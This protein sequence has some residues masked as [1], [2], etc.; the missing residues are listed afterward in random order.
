MT[1]CGN[2]LSN[3]ALE[4]TAGSHPLAAAAHRE[5]LD[6]RDIRM[7]RRD[8]R[9]C[10]GQRLRP[11]DRVRVLAVPDLVG[12][13]KRPKAETARVF[14]HLVGTY[15]RIDSF[16]RLGFVRLVFRIRRGAL[17]GLHWVGIEPH[18]LR[19]AGGSASNRP[20]ERTGSAGRS[21]PVR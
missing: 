18:L 15:R 20:L 13:G 10:N 8:R 2:R 1:A 7:A 21:T 9:D 16:D 4:R 11:G 3:P 17:K 12:M 14:Q 19:R 5:P 6:A